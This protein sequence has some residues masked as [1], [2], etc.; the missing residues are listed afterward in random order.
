MPE[1]QLR[2]RPGELFFGGPFNFTFL[3]AFRRAV[4]VTRYLCADCG[5]S[6]EW[7]DNPADVARVRKRHR[8]G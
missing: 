7:I 2:G 6:E 1:V 3:G 4:L 8:P 5:F